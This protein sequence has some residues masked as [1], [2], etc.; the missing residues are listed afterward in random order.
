MVTD[1]TKGKPLNI[2]LKFFYPLFI[3]TLVQQLFSLIDGSIIGKFGSTS[4]FAAV[5]SVGSL[6]W[7]LVSFILG[8]S[9]GAGVIVAQ[10]FGKKDYLKMKQS[11]ANGLLVCGVVCLVITSGGILFARTIL[12]IMNTPAEII[13]DAWLILVFTIAAYPATTF[14][15]FLGTLMQSVGDSKNAL[16]RSLISIVVKISLNILFVITLDLGVL[17]VGISTIIANISSAVVV[18]YF[19]KTKFP[20]IHVKKQDFKPNYHL[21]KRI[22]LI[23][24]PMGLQ[25]NITMIGVTMIQSSVNS[26]GT[27][28][29]AAFSAATRLE[30]LLTTPVA[31]LANAVV[32][33]IGQ[34]LGAGK[35]KRVYKSIKLTTILCGVYGLITGILFMILGK[36]MS[37]AYLDPSETKVLEL[38]GQYTTISGAFLTLLCLLYAIRAPIQAMGY[39]SITAFGGVIELACRAFVVIFLVSTFGY[40]AACIS[41]PL[42]WL[43]TS[44]FLYLTFLLYIRKRLNKQLLRE[45]QSKLRVNRTKCVVH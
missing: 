27:N 37:L 31:S 34:N 10:F 42:S 35:L 30:N 15:T 26:L 11:I 8:F 13:N 38:V 6:N 5:G 39:S 21:I 19:Y 32:P 17:G 33:F 2:I 16:V 7:M 25:S 1:M 14:A 40:T 43:F 18:F 12:E 28:Y 4:A 24:L 22:I 45:Q 29:V 44:L 41:N 9:S 20:E 23:G 36:Q 3:S